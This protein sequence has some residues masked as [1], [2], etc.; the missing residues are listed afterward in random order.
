MNPSNEF[1]SSRLCTLAVALLTLATLTVMFLPAPTLAQGTTGGLEGIVTD[2]GSG[3][4][5]KGVVVMLL[6]ADGR[7]LMIG[8]YTD[9][10]GKYTIPNVPP[11]MYQLRTMLRTFSA[12]TI[13]E[14]L[15]TVG[16]T[17]EYNFQ[18]AE[19]PPTGRIQGSVTDASTGEP[20]AA[21]NV[22]VLE[23]DG[24]ATRQG[25]FSNDQGE[26]IIIN[27]PEGR[28]LLRAVMPNYKTVEVEQL[29]VTARTTT[30]QLFQMEPTARG[31]IRGTVVDDDTGEAIAAVNIFVL[32]SDGTFTNL[33][34]FTDAEGAFTIINVPAGTYQLRAMMVGY[35]AAEVK[36]LL[37]T[38]GVETAQNFRLKRR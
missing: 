38:S 11:G 23:L 28:F 37:V 12:S 22:F 26:Y 3:E 9:A 25:A 17:K 27:V 5:L 7:P 32:K 21:A 13:E 6:N 36:D 35:D 24:T 8:A 18:L 31:T 16:L 20:I 19:A 30:R 10:E 1:R 14:V 29:L 2:E 4:P 34:A 33:G 15:V